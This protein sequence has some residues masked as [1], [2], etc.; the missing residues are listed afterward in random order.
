MIAQAVN[1]MNFM[2][3]P[4]QFIIPIYQRTYSNPYF[5]SPEFEGINNEAG[6]NRFKWL[7]GQ[8]KTD[9]GDD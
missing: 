1:M 7:A 8:G 2:K 5:N 6:L 3:G 9:K 4:K